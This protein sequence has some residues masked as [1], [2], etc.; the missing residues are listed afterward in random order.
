[1]NWINYSFNANLTKKK[2]T[3]TK[4]NEKQIHL[5]FEW[6]HFSLFGF[7]AKNNEQSSAN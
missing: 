7:T 1:M 5:S 6:N 2:K 3:L 4:S